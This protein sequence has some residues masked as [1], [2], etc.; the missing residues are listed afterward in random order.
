MPPH[1]II[2]VYRIS[3]P[4]NIGGFDH[5]LHKYLSAVASGDVS[6]F[7]FVA[8]TGFGNDGAD[9]AMEAMLQI[10]VN[11]VA[12]AGGSIG[13]PHLDH[14][15]GSAWVPLYYKTTADAGGNPHANVLGGIVTFSGYSTGHEKYKMFLNEVYVPEPSRVVSYASMDAQY[16]A[17]AITNFNLGTGSAG[18]GPWVWERCRDGNYLQTLISVVGAFSKHWRRKRGLG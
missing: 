2:P 18:T 5:V 4:Y 13:N 11:L 9:A 12:P 8:R 17:V 6:G 1:A 14:W 3:A 7:N 16:K 10:L 15:D